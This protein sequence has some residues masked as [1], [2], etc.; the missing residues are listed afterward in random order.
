MI[1][2]M[3]VILSFILTGV[4]GNWLM[5]SWQARNWLAQQR[6]AG[7]EKEYFALK[8]LGEE[9]AT[10]LAVRIYAMRQM[11]SALN[12]QGEKPTEVVWSDYA[13]SV[14]KWNERLPS[15]LARLPILAT[16]E[17][18]LELDE[19]QVSLRNTSLRLEKT[20][21][22]PAEVQRLEQGQINLLN[23]ELLHLHAI[24]LAFNKKILNI[25]MS[26][27]SDIFYGTKIQFSANNLEKFSTWQLFKALW[28]SDVHRYSIIR[29]PLNS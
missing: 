22:M 18:A 28:I 2:I 17:L 10:L 23:T 13:E 16:Y 5:Q 26:Q 12:F 7:H 1:T 19:I 11:K 3:S 21:R 14:K 9:I 8:E 29:T 15:F 4:I 25:V 27:R 24:T 20:K 6:F